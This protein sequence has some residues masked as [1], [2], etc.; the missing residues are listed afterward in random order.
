MF[1]VKDLYQ[2]KGKK[3]K[4]ISKKDHKIDWIGGS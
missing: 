2:I 3:V 1:E 4:H